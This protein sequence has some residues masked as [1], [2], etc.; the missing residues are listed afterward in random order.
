MI[1]HGGLAVVYGGL[2]RGRARLDTLPAARGFL[3]DGTSEPAPVG[4]PAGAGGFT[5]VAADDLDGDRHSELLA[6][7]PFAAPHS[8]ANAG[9]AV[10]FFAR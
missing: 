7:A 4:S 6:G 10:V 8:R 2:T 5:T 9:A 1:A 3:I